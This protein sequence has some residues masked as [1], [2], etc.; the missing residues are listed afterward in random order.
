MVMIQIRNVPPDLHERL[1]QRAASKG[2]NLSDYLK[3]ELDRIVSIPTNEELFEEIEADRKAGRLIGT[4]RKEIL[5]A[6]RDGRESR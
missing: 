5:D 3:R 1:K 6:I 4:T 2:M